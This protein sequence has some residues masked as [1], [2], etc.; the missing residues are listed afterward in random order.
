MNQIAI[1]IL[2]RFPLHG[3]LCLGID[4]AAAS[5]QTCGLPDSAEGAYE[6]GKRILEAADYQLAVIKPQAAYFERF[7]SAGW[8]ALEG[9]CELCREHDLPVLLDVKR[10]DIDSTALA[11][12]HAYFSPQGRIRADAIT[13]HA[14][15]G[16]DALKPLLDYGVSQGGGVFVVVRSSNPEGQ[17]L[18]QARLADGFSVAADLSRSITA[19]NHQQSS[20]GIGP[21]GAVVGATCADL[22]E[23]LANLPNSLILAPGVGAQGATLESLARQLSPADRSRLLPSVSRAILSEGGS[24]QGLRSAIGALRKEAKHWFGDLNRL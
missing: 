4:P 2:D 16:F 22:Q 24:H 6:F 9:L 13:V 10:G 8:Q 17:G 18:Q 7:G 11:Y 19:Y 15:L 14:Y 23:T 1:R 5:L 12:A 21:V 3:P 20:E